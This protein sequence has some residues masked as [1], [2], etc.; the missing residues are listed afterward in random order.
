MSEAF[1]PF[2]VLNDDLMTMQRF[3]CKFALTVTSV[4]CHNQISLCTFCN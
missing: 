1:R 2:V 4:R 3:S